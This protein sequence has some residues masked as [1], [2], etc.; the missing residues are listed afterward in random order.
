[1]EKGKKKILVLVLA[2]LSSCSSKDCWHFD[3]EK[4][5]DYFYF[6]MRNFQSTPKEQ[7]GQ[8]IVSYCNE[9]ARAYA[10]V[11]TCN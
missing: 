5:N 10:W 4:R 6:C 9:R 1:M 3:E 2:L 7:L 8:D 11:D